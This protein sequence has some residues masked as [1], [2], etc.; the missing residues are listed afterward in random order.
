VLRQGRTDKL[1]RYL[2]RL[3]SWATWNLEVGVPLPLLSQWYSALH[4]RDVGVDS[5][6]VAELD[7][8]QTTIPTMIRPKPRKISGVL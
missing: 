4:G 8:F 5:L 3:P 7:P 2:G 6:R 1:D